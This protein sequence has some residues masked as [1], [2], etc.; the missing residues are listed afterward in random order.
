[1]ARIKKRGLDYFPLDTDFMHHRVVRRIMKR[2]GD[3]ALGILVAL[4]S[5]IYA[6]EGYYLELDEN[7]LEDLAAN[8]YDCT[9]DDVR[10]VVE[11]AVEGGLFDDGLYASRRVLTSAHIQQ[12]YVFIKKQAKDKLLRPDL[13]LLPAADNAPDDDPATPADLPEKSPQSKGK[14]STANETKEN[15]PSTASGDSGTATGEA[16]GEDDKRSA[17][18]RHVRTAA[19][20]DALAPPADGLKRNYEGLLE[21]LRRFR[22]P[23]DEQYAI[24]RRTNYGVIGHPVW[25]GF[26]TLREAG[27]KIKLPGRYLLSL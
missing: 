9:A 23:P 12:Q 10:R 21:N 20:I 1:M 7:C 24:I 25:R 17:H 14:H 15:L 16:P 5:Y 13:R 11:A 26:F 18:S 2:E 4:F 22:I 6:D 8:F 19:D 3:R 27:G